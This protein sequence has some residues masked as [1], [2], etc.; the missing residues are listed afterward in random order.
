M[1]VV[2]T[3]VAVL[4]GYQANWLRQRHQALR[5]CLTPQL[6]LEVG[7]DG[8]LRH[9]SRSSPG[10][11]WLW[12]EPVYER[13]MIRFD[14]PDYRL[15]GLTAEQAEVVVRVNRLFPEASVSGFATSPDGE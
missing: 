3:I 4:I 12:G 13:I 9:A 8:R 7:P 14:G 11:P 1:F 10:S 2:V 5:E 15:P 6:R